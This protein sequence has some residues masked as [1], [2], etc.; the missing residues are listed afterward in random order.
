MSKKISNDTIDISIIFDENNT[1]KFALD[2]CSKSETI[3]K[4]CD[5]TC[6]KFNLDKKVKNKLLK[7]IIEAIEKVKQ[8][9]EKELKLKNQKKEENVKRLYY[10]A[11]EK[12]NRRYENMENVKKTKEENYL[13]SL[14]FSPKISK[15][16][17]SLCKRENGHKIEN[18][19]YN[20]HQYKKEKRNLE[21]LLDDLKWYRSMENLCVKKISSEKVK[22]SKTNHHNNLLISNLSSKIKNNSASHS[23]SKSKSKQ[24][25][26]LDI[27]AEISNNNILIENNENLENNKNKR[28]DSKLQIV[29]QVTNINLVPVGCISPTNL[30]VVKRKTSYNNT[31]SYSEIYTEKNFKRNPIRRACTMKNKKRED[32]DEIHNL[33]MLNHNQTMKENIYEKK[34]SVKRISLKKKLSNFIFDDDEDFEKDENRKNI[35]YFTFKKNKISKTTLKNTL[36]SSGSN[37]KSGIYERLY[38][39][40]RDMEEK[41]EEMRKQYM[42]TNYTFRPELNSRSISLL[43][44][45]KKEN[46]DDMINRLLNSKKISN[47]TKSMSSF[48]NHLQSTKSRSFQ[49]NTFDKHYNTTTA[50]L[51]THIVSTQ[52]SEEID[53]KR[54]R[55]KKAEEEL[56]QCLIKSNYYKHQRNKVV[57]EKIHKTI[58]KLKI[59]NLKEIFYS[60][61]ENSGHLENVPAS[62]HVKENILIPVLSIIKTRNMV[63]TLENFT[64]IISEV[65]N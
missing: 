24:K 65:W 19:L 49:T 37:S 35:N 63:L 54:I 62:D 5:Q 9:N 11:V 4:I 27:I 56:H 25:D 10:D 55:E 51:S 34:P 46:K 20:E 1:L 47:L 29:S 17:N 38:R 40:H 48:S 64:K 33:K 58:E 44:K 60:I 41:K 15:K 61:K 7:Q 14:T 59:N 3:N 32:I 31:N 52:A 30:S 50:V 22:K 13:S 57:Q 18:K 42:N 36:P 26:K 23:K 53:K 28:N 43:K 8:K 45:H 2:V 6:K 21:K 16:S 39:S 12:Y